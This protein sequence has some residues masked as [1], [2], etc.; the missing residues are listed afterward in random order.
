[1]V[2]SSILYFYYTCIV[3]AF[4]IFFTT[5]IVN[6]VKEGEGSNK[7]VANEYFTKVFLPNSFALV[8]LAIG[9]IGLNSIEYEERKLAVLSY[10]V[11]LIASAV[12]ISSIM[13]SSSRLRW[14]AD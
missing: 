2:A 13:L 10:T 3:L 1:M 8:F 9:F 7:Y 11:G 12:A 4:I 6:S 14:A 5:L